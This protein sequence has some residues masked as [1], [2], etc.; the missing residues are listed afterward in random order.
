MKKK[1]VYLNTKNYFQI[2]ILWK[3][4][5]QTNL[6]LSVKKCTLKD[7]VWPHEQGKIAH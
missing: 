5:L 1:L 4:A 3:K 7:S 6:D 2:V